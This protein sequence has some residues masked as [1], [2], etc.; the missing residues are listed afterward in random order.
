MKRP[1]RVRGGVSKGR[2]EKCI[3]GRSHQDMLFFNPSN[4][5]IIIIKYLFIELEFLY[6]LKLYES[7]MIE[8]NNII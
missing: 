1:K 6:I 8:T 7:K 5:I 2:R 4:Y 3:V